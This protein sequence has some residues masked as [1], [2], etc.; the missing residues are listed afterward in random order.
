M[1]NPKFSRTHQKDFANTLKTRVRSHLKEKNIDI[2]ANASMIAKTVLML[3]LFLVPFIILNAD[4]VSN[5]GLL[6]A[7][8]IISG[9][10]MAGIGMGVMHDA[11][12][13]SYSKNK[14]VNKIL[15]YTMN[16]IGANSTVWKIQHNVLHH[17]YTN[18][19]EVDD[20]IHMPFF[21]RFSPHDK[22]YGMHKFQFIYVWF[23]YSI[24]TLSW[25]TAKDF[26]NIVRYKKMGFLSKKGEFKKELLKLSI[27]KVL[28]YIYALVIPILVLPFTPWVTILAFLSMHLVTGLL[29]SCVFQVAHV[30]P[31]MEYPLMNEKKE[32][33]NGWIAHQ[34]MT[35]TN[36]SPNN[37]T[38]SW[39]IGGLNYQVEH[40]LFPN[41]CHVHYREISSI[42]KKTS[43]EFGIPYHIKSSFLSAI[44]EH[45][46]MLKYLGRVPEP[47][48]A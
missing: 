15:G 25:I 40:H 20:D 31:N 37:K 30:M 11:I 28:Y 7:L 29:I 13:G 36:F 2:H 19:Q 38:F 44:A 14:L 26:V 3:T 21:L 45:I 4:V 18:I 42:V 33:D 46:K 8:Y 39:L 24:S 22:K 10:G 6:F 16:L 41:I 17:T 9:L 1:N 47:I 48:K 35:T 5:V 12:H 27:W 23:F 32:V 43:M 34:L